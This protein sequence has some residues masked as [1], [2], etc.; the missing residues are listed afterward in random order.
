MA[1]QIP[2]VDAPAAQERVGR[3]AANPV[4][5]AAM[6]GAST[7]SGANFDQL[8]AYA[9]MESGLNPSAQAANS[10][11]SGLYQFTQQTWLNAVREYGAAHGLGAE[12][13]M[14]VRQGGQ[15]TVADSTARQRI[16]DLRKDPQVSS[17]L[18]A[19]H[20]RGL[21]EKLT[22]VLGRAPDPAETYLAHFLGSGGATQALQAL[23][24]T[25]D[26]PAADLLPAAAQ[27]NK[28]MFYTPDGTPMS[29]TQ[30][31]QHLR[32]RVE[33]TYT[34]LGANMPASVNVATNGAK[35]DPPEADAIGWGSNVPVHRASQQQR[36]ML[37]TLAAVF[38]RMDHA[39]DRQHR[40]R[41]LPKSVLAPLGVG[42]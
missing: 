6:R 1:F 13:A 15:L 33:R 14:I 18:A 34:S 36:A 27:A 28:P 32:D 22:P 24:A 30:F 29:M 41:G 42:V 38:T 31:M 21:A 26:R 12:A 39:T 5:L 17:E 3:V 25:P 8:L 16:L 40:Q 7:G 35:S 19:D 2:G 11:A 10:S 9:S 37:A 23:Q 4:V 20:L